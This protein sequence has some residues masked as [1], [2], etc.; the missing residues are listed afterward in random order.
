MYLFLQCFRILD[1]EDKGYLTFGDIRKVADE[2]EC[3][4]SNR[5]IRE[6]IDEADA[7]GDGQVS[8]D[9]FLIIMLRSNAFN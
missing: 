8:L 1:E 3:N 5:M 4:L 2:V 7:S 9:E 6:M